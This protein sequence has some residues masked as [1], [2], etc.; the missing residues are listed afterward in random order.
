MMIIEQPICHFSLQDDVLVEELD[1]IFEVS[2]NHF[3][4]HPDMCQIVPLIQDDLHFSGRE[5]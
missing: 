2:P 1:L 5:D 3:L 4:K